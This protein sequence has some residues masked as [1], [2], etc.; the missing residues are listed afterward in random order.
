MAISFSIIIYVANVGPMCVQLSVRPSSF[1]HFFMSLS[2]LVVFIFPNSM[3]RRRISDLTA[4]LIHGFL[5]CF[6]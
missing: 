6:L 1:L 3:L 5:L 4:L 2:F